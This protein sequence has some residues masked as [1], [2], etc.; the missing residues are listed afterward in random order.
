MLYATVR[1]RKIHVK[2]PDTVVQNGVKVD[3]LQLEMDDEW[4]EMDSIV[5]VFVARYNEEQTISEEVTKEDG[6]T[7]T[8]EKKT[9]VEKEITKEMLHTF[10]QKL[11]VPWETIVHSGMLSV[12]CTGYVGSE[13]IMTTMYPDSFW[14]IVQNGPVSGDSSIE[15]TP[16]LYDQIV[17]AAGTANAAAMAANQAKDQLLQDKANGV[18]DGSDGAA[19][20]VSV[21]STQTAS[22]GSEAQVYST[23]TDQDL[24]LHFVIPR[25]KQ[26]V[27]GQTGPQGPTG[28][29]GPKGD[30]GATGPAGADGKSAYQYAVEGGYTGTEAE[31]AAKMA[32]EIP[33]VDSTLTQSGQA[34]DAAAVGNRLSSLS[35]EI[36]TTAESKVSAHNTGT[37]THSDIRLLISG[38]TDRLN[39]LA[40]SDDTTLDQLSEIVAYIKSNRDLISSITTSKVS[41][42][43]IID[44]L[45]TNVTNKPLSAAQ[46]VALKALIDGIVIPDKL[47]NPNAL[48]FTG[49][50]S[51]SYDGSEP[52]TVAIPSGVAGGGAW[53]T[54]GTQMM[55]GVE[56]A[57]SFDLA[58]ET[59]IQIIV[60]AGWG[61]A[62]TA[63]KATVSLTLA[64]GATVEFTQQTMNGTSFSPKNIFTIFGN[65]IN[66]RQM[67][68]SK[69]EGAR[70]SSAQGSF[71]V[72]YGYDKNAEYMVA[73]AIATGITIT[74]DIAP[75]NAAI[76]KVE[77]M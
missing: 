70:Y 58:G 66:C 51:G 32:E 69:A 29:T 24:K 74:F 28:A 35:E 34:A 12:S 3:W 21:G 42:A 30:T 6:T 22:E 75:S 67:I 50:V 73:D 37:D 13:K 47:P 38:L 56:A 8:V 60:T 36:V 68:F 26:G 52:V 49:A 25:G 33:T 43:D 16:S 48:T 10:G 65:S 39:A 57:V 53:H 27:Q 18:F 2:K 23:G 40:D 46:G 44:N 19:A 64:N 41:V 1:N 72:A 71:G 5:C 31:F 76:V 62:L 61:T 45:T 4:A 63:T 11:L 14:Q 9:L 59:I 55:D 54:I 17:A 7:E 15:P 77:G 20:K